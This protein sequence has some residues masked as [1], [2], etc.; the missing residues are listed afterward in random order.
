MTFCAIAN[1]GLGM[2]PEVEGE[3]IELQVIAQHG[4]N[5]VLRD[6]ATGEPIQQILF[7]PP[8]VGQFD[9]IGIGGCYNPNIDFHGFRTADPFKGAVLHNA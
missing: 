2:T 8:P 4:N 5:L 6:N 1:L 9:K 3:N 7:K